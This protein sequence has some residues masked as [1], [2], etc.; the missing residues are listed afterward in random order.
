M[1]TWTLKKF[2]ALSP[3]ELYAILRL[4]TEVFVIE[5]N[6]IFQDMDNK[7]Q[8]AYHLMGWENDELIAYT[9]LLPPGI[10]YEISSIGRVLTSQAGRGSGAGKL[11]MQESIDQLTRLYGAVPIRIGAQVYLKK[12]YESFGFLQTSDIYDED[13]ID[14][15]EMTR[16]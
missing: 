14:H 7:D 9:R 11:L 8:H 2:E 15:I 12:F 13:G 1:I 4:R 16:D 3:H 6:C 10:S 5:Q